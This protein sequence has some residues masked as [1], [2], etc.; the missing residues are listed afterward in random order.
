MTW[1][2][3][4]QQAQYIRVFSFSLNPAQREPRVA[5]HTD[6]VL[7]CDTFLRS[8]ACTDVRLTLRDR[9]RGPD[10]L[11]CNPRVHRDQWREGA[12]A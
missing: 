2:S 8:V 7:G 5:D 3:G 12:I 10:K 4:A 11:L 9:G 6:A 1:F